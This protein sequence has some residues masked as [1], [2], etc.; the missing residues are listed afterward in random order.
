MACK[1]AAENPKDIKG[2]V[3]YASYPQ[4]DELKNTDIRVLSLWGSE[5]KVAKIDKILDAKNKV[6]S[7]STFI[8]IVGGNHGHFGDYGEQKGDG[9]STINPEKQWDEASQYTVAFLE[10]FN[11]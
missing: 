9:E 3:L 11:D 2:V 8:E 10:S 6:N 5:D 7:D 4:N 1:Y